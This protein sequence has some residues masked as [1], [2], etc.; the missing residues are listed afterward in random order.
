MSGS[1]STGCG[2]GSRPRPSSNSHP[3]KSWGYFKVPGCWPGI[4]DYMQKDSQTLYPHPAWKDAR[5]AGLTAAWYEREITVPN[6]WTGRR[7]AVSVEYLNS[8]AAVFVDGKPA[9]EIRFPGGE[10]DL[11]PACRP[12]GKHRAQHARRGHAA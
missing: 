11:T 7:I 4:T 12:G 1:A 10:L 8:Y 5:L 3:P 2:A 6:E 9:G